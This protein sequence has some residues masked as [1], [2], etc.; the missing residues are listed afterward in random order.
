MANLL[1][2]VLIT[3]AR[4]E[5]DYVEFT[6]R[7]MA[8]QTYPPLRWVIVSD[9]STDGTDE[10][11]C[12]Y[13]A[14]HPW[15]QLIR[16]P[17]RK[18]RHF[19]G[20]VHAFNAGR[21]ALGDLQYDVIGNLDADTSF[22]PDHFEYLLSQFTSDMALGVGGA[23]FVEGDS[24]YD[25]RFTNVENVWGGC[26]L[27]RTACYDDVG[28]Y[29]PRE[30][31]CIDHVAVMTARMKGWK[32]QTF[33]GK[34]C[35]H[36]RLMGTATRGIWR[37]RFRQG[38]KDYSVGNHPLWQLFRTV[39]QAAQKPYVIGGLAIGSGYFWSLLR[40]VKVAV[41]PELVQF[42]RREQMQRL[43]R[44]FG[45]KPSSRIAQDKLA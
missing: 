17:E 13:T 16:M 30:A 35:Q 36:H 28:G 2:Y 45:K 7:S 38:E 12:K 6:L 19:A 18:E 20:K 39:Y 9:G 11:V 44:V 42:V 31:G 21:E 24:R 1:S 23:P 25:Y 27:F 4:N 32:T 37:S 26:Q 3:P 43:R 40:G 29:Q 5:A 15:I 34:V 10:L 8:A 41:S 33:T 14:Q 22:E